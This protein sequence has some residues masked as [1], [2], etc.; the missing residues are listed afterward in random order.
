M[1]DPVSA[2]RSQT[3][4]RL[5][6]AAVAVFAEKG[7]LGASVEEICEAAGFT[8]GAFYSNFDSKDALCLAVLER[9]GE[10]H[11]AATHEAIAS[12]PATD[13]P[14]SASLE[15]LIDG[16]I[17][18]FLSAQRGDRAAM[19]AGIELRLYAVRTESIRAGYLAFFARISSE[20]V[21]LIESTATR[22]GYLLAVPGPQAVAVLQGVYEQSA[23]AALLAGRPDAARERTALLAGVLKSML[24]PA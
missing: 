5:V 16:A 12:L 11:L 10:G 7:V 15:Q 9:Q 18:V 14:G 17:A 4:D 24:R 2:R 21:S 19:L 13:G 23:V 3:R 20:F 6:D 1:T 8:R 22:F